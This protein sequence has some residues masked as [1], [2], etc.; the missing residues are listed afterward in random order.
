MP[1]AEYRSAG[2]AW[3]ALACASG[4]S[5]A[6]D[7]GPLA[8]PNSPACAR[9]APAPA[10]P[11]AGSTADRTPA[12]QS[13]PAQV[14]PGSYAVVEDGQRVCLDVNQANGSCRVWAATR[15]QYEHAV[16]TGIDAGMAGNA[17]L[18]DIRRRIAAA[19]PDSGAPSVQSTDAQTCVSRASADLY[20]RTGRAP[21]GDES[22]AFIQRCTRTGP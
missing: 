13:S 22:F 7:C 20:R 9:S 14:I 11:F 15:S 5:A 2:L 6:Q 3:L 8:D 1:R 21:T 17:M 16:Q 18:A 19:A 4:W 10:N 12:A